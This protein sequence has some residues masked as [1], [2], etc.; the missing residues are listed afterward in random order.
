MT[1]LKFI[2]DDGQ[3]ESFKINCLSET[4]QPSRREKE[5]EKI[6]TVDFEWFRIRSDI[7]TLALYQSNPVTYVQ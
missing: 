4:E 7:T 1:V 2:D 6:S 3:C 5:I